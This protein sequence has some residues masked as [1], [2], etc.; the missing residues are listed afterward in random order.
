MPQTEHKTPRKTLL[1][2]LRQNVPL[3]DRYTPLYNAD[4]LKVSRKFGL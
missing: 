1:G 3:L 2:T 4:H